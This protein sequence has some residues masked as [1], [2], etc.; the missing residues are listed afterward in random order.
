MTLH[1]DMRRRQRGITI[2]DIKQAIMNG[3]IIEDYPADYPYPSC[4][5]LGYTMDKAPLH[6]VC[7]ASGEDLYI[8]TVYRPSPEKWERDWKTRKEPE[9]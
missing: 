6:L 8:V 2:P 4:L 5:I 7:G 1:A 9:T 3:E